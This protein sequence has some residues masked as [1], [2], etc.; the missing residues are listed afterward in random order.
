[1]SQTFWT[2]LFLTHC[3]GQGSFNRRISESW[4]AESSSIATLIAFHITRNLPS[5]FHHRKKPFWYW[6]IRPRSCEWIH[7]P[8]RSACYRFCE[9]LASW[10]MIFKRLPFFAWV[11]EMQQS[12]LVNFSVFFIPRE[13]KALSPIQESFARL[14]GYFPSCPSWNELFIFLVF[15]Q[16]AVIPSVYNDNFI[17]WKVR[18]RTTFNVLDLKTKSAT[19]CEPR[20]LIIFNERTVWKKIAVDILWRKSIEKGRN[21]TLVYELESQLNWTKNRNAV[22]VIQDWHILIFSGTGRRLQGSPE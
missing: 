2:G 14:H 13:Y 18:G 10:W 1:M 19:E 7:F 6:K 17:I 15:V 12:L 11:K 8:L 21:G 9:S 16:V 4:S 22:C 5:P 20:G 3:S